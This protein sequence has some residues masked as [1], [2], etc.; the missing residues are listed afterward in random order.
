[1]KP[2]GRKLRRFGLALAVPAVLLAL[3]L[4]AGSVYYAA[5]GGRACI[6]CHEV[7]PAYATWAVSAH[8]AVACR[9]CHGSIFST[10]PAFHLNNVRQLWRHLRGQ[11]P[12]RLLVQQRDI[13]RG[14]S[15]RCGRCHE[16]EFAGWSA[17]KHHATYGRIFLT[18][19]H[20]AQRLLTDQCL[21]C[22]GM[23]FERSIRSLVGPL[24][25][26]GPWRLA[27]TTVR[28]DE[29]AIPC[30]ACHEAHR[31][32]L[33]RALRAVALAGH[34]SEPVPSPA[35]F[36]DRREQVH[37]PVEALPLPAMRD[38]VRPV[39]VSPDPRQAV[40]YQCHA[41]DHTF[42]V[43][44]GDD[45]TCVGVHEGLSCLACHA[46]HDLDARASCAT[47]H[48]RLSN[49]GLDVAQMD[50]T[51]K[52]ATS[53]HNIHFVKCADCHTTG[54]PERKPAAPEHHQM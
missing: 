45:R 43:G 50:T 36:Y 51:F 48:P 41:P 7:A 32:G 37:Y 46:G 27:T 31:P 6:R 54:V 53:R 24:N 28:P 30:L 42:Q 39:R 38:G 1:V 3:A 5:A 49:C 47:C 17:G 13:S 12:E 2:A 33:P 35:A 44:S 10:D 16:A 25:L 18:A 29:P 19:E 11:V 23:Y 4:P 9:D 52:A 22:H 34:P 15:E 40:C 21:Q 14:M 26:L 20:N 8:R